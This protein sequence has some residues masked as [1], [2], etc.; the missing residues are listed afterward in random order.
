MQRHLPNPSKLHFDPLANEL[1]S[2]G[3][4][5]VARPATIAG[6]EKFEYR[7]RSVRKYLWRFR[8]VSAAVLAARTQQTVLFVGSSGE[9]QQSRAWNSI[10]ELGVQS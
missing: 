1:F 7:N 8:F 6:K 9:F 10:E 5:F 3:I 4:I 2:Q